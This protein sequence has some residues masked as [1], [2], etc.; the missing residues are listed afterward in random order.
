MVLAGLAIALAGATLWAAARLG[1]GRLPGD[2][3]I[4]RGNVHVAIPIVTSIV[5]SIILTIALNVVIRLWR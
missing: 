4:D 2:V 1:L 5:I 3:V